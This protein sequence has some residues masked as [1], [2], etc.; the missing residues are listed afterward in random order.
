MV[1]L[2]NGHYTSW[3]TQCFFSQGVFLIN[4]SSFLGA[5]VQRVFPFLKSNRSHLH[6]DVH[7]PD[8]APRVLRLAQD[9]VTLKTWIEGYLCIA[10]FL[11]AG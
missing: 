1:Y 10:L 2:F 11:C 4:I 6:N 9:A 3:T 5:F 7:R 8:G